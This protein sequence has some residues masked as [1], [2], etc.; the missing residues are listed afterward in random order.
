MH[1]NIANND[2]QVFFFVDTFVGIEAMFR[3][4]KHPQMVVFVDLEACLW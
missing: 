1:F 3:G 4:L 2:L